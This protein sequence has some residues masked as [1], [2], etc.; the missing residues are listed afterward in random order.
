MLFLF[1]LLVVCVYTSAYRCGRLLLHVHTTRTTLHDELHW[2]RSAFASHF[3]ETWT[4]NT[5]CACACCLLIG[6]GSQP[7]SAR[8][9]IPRCASAR[10]RR[11]NCS[12]GDPAYSDGAGVE[13]R[14]GLGFAGCVGSPLNAVKCSTAMATISCWACVKPRRVLFALLWDANVVGVLMAH[15]SNA[16]M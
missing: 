7:S 2:Y 6:T 1:L 9:A 13:D 11:S 8:V 4:T 12:H 16:F 14:A 15:P 3:T 5:P 10:A